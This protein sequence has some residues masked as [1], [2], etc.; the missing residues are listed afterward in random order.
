VS[1]SSYIFESKLGL[2]KVR[3]DFLSPSAIG[4]EPL[5]QFTAP[6]GV[7]PYLALTRG[8]MLG[9]FSPV[10]SLMGTLDEVSL[11]TGARKL[12][13]GREIGGKG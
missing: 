5:S 3:R 8:A 7:L 6:G 12:L 9:M 4:L 13:Q 11:R 2:S 10:L 1:F